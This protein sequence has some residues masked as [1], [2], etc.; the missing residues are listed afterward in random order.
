MIAGRS[1]DKTRTLIAAALFLLCTFGLDS[2]FPRSAGA[3]VPDEDL[4]PID[5]DLLEIRLSR[6][7]FNRRR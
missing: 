5:D 7:V 6:A 2:S 3:V 4:L 1:G